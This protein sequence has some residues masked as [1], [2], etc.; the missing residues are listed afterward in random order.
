MEQFMQTSIKPE[1]IGKAI[2]MRLAKMNDKEREEHIQRQIH[3]RKLH[4][5][6]NRDSRYGWEAE[7]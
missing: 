1:K 6:K 4:K 2:K 7:Y 3:K 5:A